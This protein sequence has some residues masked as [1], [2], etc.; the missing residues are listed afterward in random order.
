M[1]EKRRKGDD[2]ESKSESKAEASKQELSGEE[3]E[4]AGGLEDADT[5]AEPACHVDLGNKPDFLGGSSPLFGASSST[6]RIRRRRI[7]MLRIPRTR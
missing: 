4:C 3:S 7:R 2:R 5:D 1:K 6:T